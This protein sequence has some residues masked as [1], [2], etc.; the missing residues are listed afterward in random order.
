MVT[1]VGLAMMAAAF[2]GFFDLWILSPETEQMMQAAGADTAQD[3]SVALLLSGVAAA[4]I[5][6]LVRLKVGGS[7][8]GEQGE[9]ELDLRNREVLA[10]VGLAWFVACFFAALPFVIWPRLAGIDEHVLL[11]PVNCLFESMSGL[12]T[13]GAT[14]IPD[15]DTVPRPLLLWR[16]LTHWIGG[17]GIV[18]VFLVILPSVGA[19]RQRLFQVETPGPDISERGLRP[20]AGEAA[21]KL[22]T[23]YLMTYNSLISVLS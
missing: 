14:I 19:A 7:P 10:L 1:L 18:V 2:W 23:L 12:T 5:A 16:S 8:R 22:T 20:T 3:A 9:R 17:I 6:G 13:T 4:G 11:H 21:K 15:L